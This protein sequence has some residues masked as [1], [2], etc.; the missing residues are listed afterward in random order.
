MLIGAPAA[1]SPSRLIAQGTPPTSQLGWM[2]LPPKIVR[3]VKKQ[4]PDAPH[5]T[6]LVIDATTGQ[7]GL[8]QAEAFGEVADLALGGRRI[9]MSSG[10]GSGGGILV[11]IGL[12]IAAALFK[13]RET[14]QIDHMNDLKG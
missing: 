11:A 13:N 12:A 10:R 2:S 14:V 6:L 9:R 5:E 3:V 7:N 4:L 1:S 8:A